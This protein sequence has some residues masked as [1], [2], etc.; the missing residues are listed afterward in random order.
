MMSLF[1]CCCSV[2]RCGRVAKWNHP[3]VGDGASCSSERDFVVQCRNN[4]R[5]IE[6]N[7]ASVVA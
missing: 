2:V 6:V 3:Q 5:R 1:C 4:F 7:G